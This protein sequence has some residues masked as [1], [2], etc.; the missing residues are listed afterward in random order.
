MNKQECIDRANRARH[1][2]KVR[3]ASATLYASEFG[4]NSDL[5]QKAF[6]DADVAAEAALKWDWLASVHHKTRNSLI[7]NKS[8]PAFMFGF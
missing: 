1:E 8:L 6:L 5:A 2:Q 7:R 4:G 3:T